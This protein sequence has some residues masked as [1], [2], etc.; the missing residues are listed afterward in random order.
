MESAVGK[1][2]KIFLNWIV[3]TNNSTQEQSSKNDSPFLY[4]RHLH[5]TVLEI[6]HL[7]S[8]EELDLSPVYLPLTRVQYLFI[9]TFRTQICR[10][11][12]LPFTEF[13]Q[14][15]YTNKE[16]YHHSQMFSDIRS[17]PASPSDTNIPLLL[18]LPQ[19]SSAYSRT[20]HKWNYRIW[21]LV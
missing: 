19:L 21:T 11:L 5:T 4:L 15:V 3:M 14:L 20:S 18:F 8:K 17:P 10:N 1:L 7:T 2:Q 13:W 6:P 16:H 12:N 9:G